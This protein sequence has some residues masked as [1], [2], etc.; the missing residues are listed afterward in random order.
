MHIED[1]SPSTSRH[2]GNLMKNG[3]R[4][5]KDVKNGDR[6]PASCSFR[7]D[8]SDNIY[9]IADLDNFKGFFEF[10]EQ[11]AENLKKN[12]IQMAK[13]KQLAPDLEPELFIHIYA[14]GAGLNKQYPDRTADFKPRK[15]TTFLRQPKGVAELIEAKQ[16]ACIEHSI[17][18]N[19]Y[20][21]RQ[22]YD[23][24]IFSGA[25]LRSFEEN[26]ENM[27]EKH[28]W[29]RI[30][31]PKG[32]YIY[33]PANPMQVYPRIMAM[34]ATEQQQKEFEE[35]IRHLSKDESVFLATRSVIAGLEQSVSYYG[36]AACLEGGDYVLKSDIISKENNALV[37]IQNMQKLT[38]RGR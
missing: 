16:A 25:W 36:V 15:R 3:C 28:T 19:E 34:D 13:A 26:K 4:I 9:I 31:T 35:K 20:L 2:T 17:L 22:G 14:F 24:E 1:L 21:R 33:D 11:R 37:N 23:T 6:I 8:G 7:D 12:P 38:N 27:S 32:N 5:I 10:V 29:V 30:K 18:A